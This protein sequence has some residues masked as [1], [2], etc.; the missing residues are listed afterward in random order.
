MRKLKEKLTKER[1][2]DELDARAVQI[3]EAYKWVGNEH[4]QARKL[5][6]QQ[7]GNELWSDDLNRLRRETRESKIFWQLTR[8]HEEIR[9]FTE[10]KACEKS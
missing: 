3:Q 8:N 1:L 6:D 7:N 2:G 4:M 9:I 5:V 10:L